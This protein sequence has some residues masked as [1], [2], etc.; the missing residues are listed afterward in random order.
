MSVSYYIGCEII[1]FAL[2]FVARRFAY[3]L[4]HQN[5]KENMTREAKI[6]KHQQQQ[7]T[8]RTVIKKSH[9]YWLTTAVQKYLWAC[10]GIWD[11]FP[12]A[13]EHWEKE[14]NKSDYFLFIRFVAFQFHS[15]FIFLFAVT[16]AS[17][18]KGSEIICISVYVCMWFC[19]NL[20]DICT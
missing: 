9:M 10:A 1:V 19:W 16:T 12:E 2:C 17:T 3:T 6:K 5:D 15:L 4:S 11:W 13:V 14:P 20:A 8:R 7:I 18:S